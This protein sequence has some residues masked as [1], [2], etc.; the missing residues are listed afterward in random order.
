M[1]EVFLARD[2]DLDRLVAIKYLRSD[3]TASDWQDNLRREARLL[4]KL[5]HPNIVQVYDIFELD[6]I[7]ALVM[8]Y[9]EGQNLYKVL[10]ERRCELSECLRW[11][12]EIA[13][14]LAAAH[15]VGITHN[16]LKAENILI[17]AQGVAKVTDFG[18]AAAGTDSNADIQALG[19]LMARLLQD[20]SGLSPGLLQLTAELNEQHPRKQHSAQQA[21]SLIRN[22]WLD[23]TQEE[24]ALPASPDSRQRNNY[25]LPAFVGLAVLAALA[26]FLYTLATAPGSPERLSYLAV[27]PTVVSNSGTLSEQQQRNLRSTVQQALQQSV[28]ASSGLALVGSQEVLQDDDDFVEIASALGADQMIASFLDC[29]KLNCELTI[30]WLSGENFSVSGHR[31]TA[32]FVD[33]TLETYSIVQRQWDQLYPGHGIEQDA[34]DLISEEAYQEYITLYNNSHVGGGIESETIARLEVLIGEFN[35]FRPLYDLYAHAALEMYD[36]TGSTAYLDRL[37]VVLTRAETWMGDSILLR[38]AWFKL[39]VEQQQYQQAEQEVEKIVRLGGDEVLVNTLL[40]DLNSYQAKYE[41][42]DKFYTRALLLKPTRAVYYNTAYNLKEWGK[43]ERAA[44]LLHLSLSLY[45]N[46]MDAHGLL[47]WMLLEQGDLPG[48]IAQFEQAV[49]IQPNTIYYNNIGLAYMLQ[50]NYLEARNQFLSLYESGNRQQFVVLNLA[51]SEQLL[52][53]TGQAE[54]LYQSLIERRTSGDYSV[55]PS[56]LSQAYAQLGLF[57]QAIATFDSIDEVGGDRSNTTFTKA[58]VYALA[59]QNIAALVQID[60]ALASGYG[61]IWF[62]LPWFGSLCTEQKFAAILE[63]SSFRETCAGHDIPNG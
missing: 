1:G 37:K 24:T 39:F 9:V 47:G 18:I 44:E 60:T 14:G 29:S 56:V 33:A 25:R 11:L 52:G 6:G 48:A 2:L 35:R 5:S 58:L 22:A 32:I 7:A 4:A 21:A 50:G 63:Q 59:G 38:R 45:P 15:A 23:A 43:L 16:D 26:V 42:A 10:R 34:R 54:Q 3:L 17:S 30:E 62:T 49:K 51:D 12:E 61:L 13:T 57:A 27:L 40:G 55:Y 20:R 36:E 31:R 53:N 8:E 46:D 28:L 41:K 19:K